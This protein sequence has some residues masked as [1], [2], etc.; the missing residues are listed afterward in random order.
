[1]DLRVVYEW[2]FGS[3]APICFLR[4]FISY[5]LFV[6]MCATRNLSHII[7]VSFKNNMTGPTSAQDFTRGFQW[8]SIFFIFSV[9]FCLFILLIVNFVLS[10]L[11]RLTDSDYFFCI[12]IFFFKNQQQQYKHMCKTKQNIQKHHQII[13]VANKAYIPSWTVPSGQKQP[14]IQ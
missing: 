9:V 3:S 6:F 12:F 14:S 5:F 1:M 10:A 11:L 8:G 7:F 13:S 4:W 2:I